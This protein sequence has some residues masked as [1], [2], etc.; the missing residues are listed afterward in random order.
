MTFSADGAKVQCHVCGRWLRALNTHLTTHGLNAQSYKETYDLP[1]T[2]S[3]W[4]PA[5]QEKARRAALDRD[6]GSVGRAHI[7]P[8]KGRPKGQE[9]RLGARIKASEDRKGIY[10]RGGNKTTS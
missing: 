10:T 7:P 6:Q 4:P 3:M 2:I 5:T 1:R 9:P 8:A